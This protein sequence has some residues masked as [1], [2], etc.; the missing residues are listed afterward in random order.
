MLKDPVAR[1]DFSKT[2]PL[3][4]MQVL[5]AEFPRGRSFAIKDVNLTGF[6]KFAALLSQ[7]LVAVIGI[8]RLSVPRA[9][10]SVSR[11]DGE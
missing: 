4:A 6:R 11:T 9:G 5:S 2:S 10:P 7:S 8:A 1:G 3:Q